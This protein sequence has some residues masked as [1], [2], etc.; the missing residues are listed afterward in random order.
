MEHKWNGNCCSFKYGY[1]MLPS[2]DGTIC[3]MLKILVS[4]DTILTTQATDNMVFSDG[5]YLFS[6]KTVVPIIAALITS[7]TIWYE[8]NIFSQSYRRFKLQDAL[9]NWLL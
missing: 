1:I 9:S 3:T 6:S 7:Q 8:V 5:L 4:S 2:A